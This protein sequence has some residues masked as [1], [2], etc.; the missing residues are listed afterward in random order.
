MKSG[1]TLLEIVIVVGII[2]LLLAAGLPRLF[3]LRVPAQQEFIARLNA[4][5]QQGAQAAL[6]TSQVQTIRFNLARKVVE[7]DNTQVQVTI[8][9]ALKIQDIII[10]GESQIDDRTVEVRVYITPQG[11]TQNVKVLLSEQGR[12]TTYS[13]NP[14]TVH[15]AAPV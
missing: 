7:R 2:G 4:F 9:E 6:E 5:M 11:R 12:T 3:K 1:F 8:P 13:L 10:N 15:F 14:F